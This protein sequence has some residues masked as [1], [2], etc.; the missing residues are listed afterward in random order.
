MYKYNLELLWWRG[1]EVGYIWIQ[2]QQ[3][4]INQNLLSN[5]Q[6]N[7]F[8]SALWATSLTS[9]RGSY[10]HYGNPHEVPVVMSYLAKR[11]S[12]WLGTSGQTELYY[13]NW[14]DKE[15]PKIVR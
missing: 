3:V 5:V 15:K 14:E 10:N 13:W 9:W 4:T 6:F 11:R 7:D 8:T 12:T 2:I 1:S